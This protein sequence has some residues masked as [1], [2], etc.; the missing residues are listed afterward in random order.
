MQKN[1]GGDRGKGPNKTGTLAKP[2]R[3]AVASTPGRKSVKGEP[4]RG[5]AGGKHAAQR[6]RGAR[7]S[8]TRKAGPKKTPRGTT[9]RSGDK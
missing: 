5:A 9:T 1:Q 4:K 3:E 2:K 7:T 6:A 8:E